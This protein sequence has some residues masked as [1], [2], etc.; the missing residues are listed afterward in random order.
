MAGWHLELQQPNPQ[1]LALDV[2]A[3]VTLSIFISIS[4]SQCYTLIEICQTPDRSLLFLLLEN[5]TNVATHAVLILKMQIH[6]W[7]ITC[8]PLLWGQQVMFSSTTKPLWPAALRPCSE[9]W[10]RLTVYEWEAKENRK[11][12]HCI[13]F[14]QIMQ[15]R[16][17]TAVSNWSVRMCSM[18]FSCCVTNKEHRG[19][20]R[21]RTASVVKRLLLS[22]W[23]DAIFTFLYLPLCLGGRSLVF[24]HKEVLLWRER[25]CFSFQRAWL[26]RIH[27]KHQRIH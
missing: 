24:A 1:P 22:V 10:Q 18:L 13:L 27:R 8:C 16:V 25:C 11:T 6:I 2:A 26:S 3:I 5:L 19:L 23:L 14:I 20:H 9:Q 17:R 7:L 12:L 4:A 21:K 15:G